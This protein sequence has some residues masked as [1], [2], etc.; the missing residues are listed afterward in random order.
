MVSEFIVL[1]TAIEAVSGPWS[2]Y[3]GKLMQAAPESFDDRRA[4]EIAVTV[5][6]MRLAG[7]PISFQGLAEKHIGLI[8]FIG[9]ELG[10]AALPAAEA[11]F[12]AKKCWEA[13]QIRRTKAS[14]AKALNQLGDKPESAQETIAAVRKDIDEVLTSSNSLAERLAERLF[15]PVA[16][17]PKPEPRY[18][19]EGIP[20][21]TAGNLTT[22]SAP[23]KA[24]KSAVTGAML[25]SVF[26]VDNADCLGFKSANPHAHAVLHLDTEQS[27]FDH[28][29]GVWRIIRRAQIEAAPSWLLSYCLTGLSAVEI[30]AAI[31]TLIKDS[32]EK[33]GGMH[34]VVIDG[35][36]DSANDVNDP[37]EA[38][39]IVAELQNLAIE[40]NCPV[41]GIIHVNPGSDFKTRG[42]LGSQLE[43]KS[44][45]NL[46]L[47]KDDG[48][49]VVFADK[50]R[51]A[52]IP[53]KTGPK[54]SWNDEAK[55]HSTH[56][57]WRSAKQEA[58]KLRLAAH[59]KTVFVTANA[60]AI[61]Y[62]RL[63][64]LLTMEAHCSVSTAKRNVAQMMKL[65]IITKNTGGLYSLNN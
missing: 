58:D 28:Q 62:S 60:P 44:E 15:S 54:F 5:K 37:A 34:S 3:V 29:D 50:N 20:I 48:V 49:T 23:A 9:T 17:I 19:L 51:R 8:T 53:K 11:E 10:T 42:H 32:A 63:T 16:T 31:S 27:R 4:G 39:A 30:R 43:R 6:S 59:A 18:W 47:E 21:C 1:A 55:M 52:P 26:A 64:E 7:E 22:I 57:T 14:L 12:H 61:P 36:A 46:R 35:V 45:T 38:G 56:K 24:G 2:S 13:F 41:I 25:A 65:E 33:Y 40:F